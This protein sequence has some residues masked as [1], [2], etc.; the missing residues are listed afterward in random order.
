M[1]LKKLTIM[2]VA[3]VLALPSLAQADDIN[4][5]AGNSKVNMSQDGSINVQAGKTNINVDSRE[6]LAQVNVRR[7][8]RVRNAPRRAPAARKNPRTTPA[9]RANSK[10]NPATRVNTVTRSPSINS[11]NNSVIKPPVNPATPSQIRNTQTSSCN[12]DINY[13]SNQQTTQITGS[14]R[15]VY[16]SNVSTTCP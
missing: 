6:S 4:I 15:Q 13:S 8:P 12:D 10:P 2:V 1:L 7:N 14:G 16:Q 5:E 11:I 3:F 9:A